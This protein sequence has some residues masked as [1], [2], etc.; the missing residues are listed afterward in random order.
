MAR[1]VVLSNGRLHVGI[2]LYAEVHDFYFPYVGQ[3]N[4]AAS[5]NLRHRIGVFVDG[6]VS[7]L[8]NGS[9]RFSYSYHTASLIGNIQAVNDS[10]GI[11]LEFD[12]CVD[13]EQDVFLRNIHVV[14]SRDEDR[15]VKLFMHQVFDISDAAGNGD[16]IQYLPDSHAILTYRGQR[17]FVIGGSNAFGKP[18]D[19]HSV[20][21]FGIEG[22]EGTFADAEDGILAN[23]SVEHGR[24]DS[25]IG[26]T[27][28]IPAHSSSRAYYWISVAT[29]IR[30]AIDRHDDILNKNM[31][32]N[33][34]LATS[35]WWHNW[36]KPA[37][38]FAQKLDPEYTKSFIQSIL[39]IKANIDHRGSVIAS[40]DTTMLHHSRDA[41]GYCWP[42][43][44]AY[45][46]WPLI[47]IGYKDEP[48]K[49]FEFCRRALHPKGYL[50]HKY[51]SDG[52]QGASWHGYV[53]EGG[54]EAPPIQE[55]ETAIVLFV[56]AQFY[57]T[58]KSNKL[59]REFL[60]RDFYDSLIKPMA[61][62][63]VSYT[64]PKTGL[65]KPS[66][67]LWEERFRTSTYTVSTVYGALLAA[68]GLAE[69]ANDSESAVRWRTAATDLL[70]NAQ[71]Q[72][73]NSDRGVFY[74]GF[75]LVDGHMEKDDSIDS[76]A[77]FGAFM[78]GLYSYDSPEVT[79]SFKTMYEAL[80]MPQAD[81]LGLA[82]YEND[83]YY[84]VSKDI[85][86]N[87]WFITALWQAQYYIESDRRE[88]AMKILKWCQDNMMD[89]GVLPEQLNPFDKK[90]ISVAPLTWSQAEYASTLLDLISEAEPE[91]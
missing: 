74:R 45:A 22:H 18:F 28:H 69:A 78:Y 55:D 76:S 9:W 82:R 20:G 47:R 2:N 67:D 36:I 35:R 40:T 48:L 19:Q 15:E 38:H 8:D 13:A 10:I 65:P 25:T 26:F 4:H 88:E 39:L 58:N 30:T 14:N 86:G 29:D 60:L 84:R 32:V 72:L 75:K 7:W 85:P 68:A 31:V 5:K 54:I 44:G 33:R 59:M 91:S 70:E 6:S 42:R 51:Q 16:T 73:Y 63:L 64:D 83:N 50:Y 1:P 21:L 49:F 71:K 12:D 52:S 79:S 62:F 17:A 90:Y 24:V 56:F 61:D 23:N 27:M 53:H 66:Y 43:D 37:E 46:V 57:D 34:I 81:V 80:K 11:T 3:E 87:P 89:T 77:V 41:Y